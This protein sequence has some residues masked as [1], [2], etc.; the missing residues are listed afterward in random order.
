M[1]EVTKIALRSIEDDRL[2]T[3]RYLTPEDVLDYLQDESHFKSLSDVLKETMVKAGICRE[4]DAPSVFTNELYTRLQQQDADCGK[5]DKRARITVDR[6]IS[7]FT[8]RI[9]YR[10]DVIEICFALNLDTTLSRELLC[11]CGFSYFN[12]RDAEDATYLYCMINHRPL[13]AAKA[14]LS[15][16]KRSEAPTAEQEDAD[17]TRHSGSTTIL[18]G[19]QLLGDSSWEND[20]DFL[21]TFLIPNKAKFLGFSF[22][23]IKAYYAIK[24]NLFLAVLLDILN[25]EDHHEGDRNRYNKRVETAESDPD[26]RTDD[27]SASLA[28]RSAFKKPDSTSK[29]YDIGQKLFNKRA[30]PREALLKVRERVSDH[31]ADI[32]AD[33]A[34][35]KE[36]SLFLNDI[37]KNEGLLKR[38]VYSIRNQDGRIRQYR[39]SKLKDTVMKEFPDDKTFADFENDP[40]IVYHGMATRKAIILMYYITYAYEFP[41]FLTDFEYTAKSIESIAKALNLSDR[42]DAFNDFAQMGFASFLRSL[43]LILD[44]CRLPLLY[45]ANQFDWFILR[46]IRE[47]EICESIEDGEDALI[48]F[49][50]VLSYSFGDSTED[51]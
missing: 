33:I 8:K 32:T 37:I 45:P 18:L 50:R 19:N 16:Y 11:K 14:I 3:N 23:T 48:F 36:I 5:T 41:F 34:A 21:N 44:R 24:N 47:I 9:R 25:D 10:Y 1:K 27:I 31:Y 28:V 17:E 38:V 4:S 6:W 42:E 39:E 13:S 12:I 43:N 30:T 40:S 15:N 20:E 26:V 46:S 2:L 22:N 49:N 29:L 35:Q 51:D 7:G